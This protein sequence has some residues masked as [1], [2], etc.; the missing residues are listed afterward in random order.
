MKIHPATDHQYRT[1]PRPERSENGIRDKRKKSMVA[2][3]SPVWGVTQACGITLMSTTV[4]RHL[5]PEIGKAGDSRIARSAID[6]MLRNG[7]DRAILDE[8]VRL[9]PVQGRTGATTLPPIF[10]EMLQ[11]MGIDPHVV[12]PCPSLRIAAFP[13]CRT[14]GAVR[15][16]RS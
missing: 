3:T 11:Q 13:C 16:S 12:S 1:S 2:S 10:E 5:V 4:I 9:H 6:G 8:L 14:C 15:L 7:Y